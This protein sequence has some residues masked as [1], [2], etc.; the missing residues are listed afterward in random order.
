MKKVLTSWSLDAL[1]ADMI[2]KFRECWKNPFLSPAVVFTDAKMEQWFKLRW[3]R[4]NP[5]ENSVMMNLKTMRLQSFLFEI[6]GSDGERLSVEL[7][8]DVIIQHLT[9]QKPQNPQ[10]A[11][12]ISDP[13]RLYDFAQKIA[14]L[15]MDYEDTRPDSLATLLAKDDF[16]RQLYNDIFSEPDAGGGISINGRKFF[17]LYQR[18]NHNKATHNGTAEFQWDFR[19][20]VFIF[21][22]SGIGQLYRKILANFSD[23]AQLFV[24]LQTG[25]RIPGK[26]SADE[27]GQENQNVFCREWG[28][29][30]AECL[31]LWT[32]DS[33]TAVIKSERKTDSVL[34][35]VQNAIA[36]GAAFPENP[37]ENPQKPDAS[38]TLTSAPTKLR[39]VEAVHSKICWLLKEGKANLGDILVVSPKIQD[40]KIAIEQVFDQNDRFDGDFAFVPYTIADYSADSSLT[41]EAMRTLFSIL[42]KGYL[43]RADIF[44]L[45]R[46]SLVQTVRGISDEMVCEWSAWTSELNIYRKN[47]RNALSRLLLSRLTSEPV[48]LGGENLIPY[49]TISTKDDGS[50]YQFVQAVEELERWTEFSRKT[51]LNADDITEIQIFLR[52][53]LMLK[54]S[55]PDGM[56]TESFIFQNIIEETERQKMMCDFPAGKSGEVITDCFAFALLDRSCATSLHSAGILSGGVTFANFES[57]RVLSAKYVF[58]MGLDSK[59]YP[60]QDTQSVLDLRG[61]HFNSER[62]KGDESLPV[63]NKNAFLCQ[64]M[65]S[66][67]GFFLSYVNKNLQKDENFFPSSVVTTLFD[68]VFGKCDYEEK[69]SLDENRPWHELFTHREFRNKTNFLRLTKTPGAENA[70]KIPGQENHQDSSGRNFTG[71]HSQDNGEK[72]RP[73]FVSIYTIKKYLTDPFQF[74]VGQIFSAD[75]ND[76]TDEIVEFEPVVFTNLTESSL[77]KKYVRAKLEGSQNI[78]DFRQALKDS[79]LLPED[80]F[81]DVALER[82]RETAETIVGFIRASIPDASPL[83]FE[84]KAELPQI[85]G[86]LAWHNMD[87]TETG[88]LTTIEL[89]SSKNCLGGYVS[90]LAILAAL[91]ETDTKKYAIRMLVIGKDGKSLEER[92]FEMNRAVAQEMLDYICGRMFD[93]GFKPCI[94]FEFLEGDVPESLSDFAYKLDDGH[95]RGAWAY[96]DKKKLF[97]PATD[98]GYSAEN[99]QAEFLA[100]KEQQKSLLAFLSGAEKGDGDE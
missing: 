55:I 6:T 10:I 18:Y 38:L 57:N 29:F 30:G 34:H 21:G 78:A 81:G 50:L 77:R 75:D 94:P 61:S 24:Y 99:F 64:L 13:A 4:G 62:E 14:S 74:M 65:A 27:S 53:W 84:K 89:N 87:F 40:Y 42:K 51:T 95:G 69:I 54:D 48:A 9:A 26:K 28:E 72:I 22:F 45:L 17:S 97:D 58:F 63:K 35:R 19:R 98:I 8:R 79:G 52:G 91:P 100:A 3:L 12:Y 47:K 59:T 37:Q 86:T 23:R 36:E 85:T 44:S 5:S 73:D 71:T 66:T 96:F 20:P 49:E 15:F 92:H 43:S 83:A 56:F 41:A 76:A 80:F 82:I 68:A 31:E 88:T 7:L 2:Y 90:S 33:E 16:Q 67:D 93:S 11:R 60:A 46:N 1:A 32:D 39:E 70:Q 25:E